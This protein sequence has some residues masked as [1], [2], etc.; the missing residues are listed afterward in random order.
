MSKT[1]QPLILWPQ[2]ALAQCSA[3]M[4]GNVNHLLGVTAADAL[5]KT[6]YSTP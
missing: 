2:K 4:Q 6:A 5:M 1:K 3:I